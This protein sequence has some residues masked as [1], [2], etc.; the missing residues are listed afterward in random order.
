M[1]L[2][3]L[4]NRL[5][6]QT[7]HNLPTLA[8]MPDANRQAVPSWPQASCAGLQQVLKNGCPKP[9]RQ[10][11]HFGV[12]RKI[13]LGYY[14]TTTRCTWRPLAVVQ[15]STSYPFC[16]A[17]DIAAESGKMVGLAGSYPNL[18]VSRTPHLRT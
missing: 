17:Y 1:I 7:Y 11:F 16:F 15:S 18:G 9:V 10:P 12:K 4:T 2:E 6:I 5:G 14:S 3:Q 13:S 8:K